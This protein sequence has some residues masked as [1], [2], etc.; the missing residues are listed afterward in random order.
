MDA[1]LKV[2]CIVNLSLGQQRSL[3]D[4]LRLIHHH[5]RNRAKSSRGGLVKGVRTALFSA[6]VR[7]PPDRVRL[8]ISISRALDADEREYSLPELVRRY[9]HDLERCAIRRA[10]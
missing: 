2:D 9:I 3:L 8:Y 6:A 1:D 7:S 10:T 4:W 5:G